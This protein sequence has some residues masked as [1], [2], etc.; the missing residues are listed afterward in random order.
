MKKLLALLLAGMMVFSL[1]ACGGG[2]K[3]EENNAPAVEEPAGVKVELKDA[4]G[5]VS[6]DVYYPEAAELD[7]L[8]YSDSKSLLQDDGDYKID[9][10]LVADDRYEKLKG[11][12]KMGSDVTEGKFG[13]YDCITCLKDGNYVTF[14][15]LEK[16]DDKDVYLEI[17]VS[18]GSSENTTP[19]KEIYDTNAEVKE[20]IESFVYNGKI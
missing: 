20:I 17:L 8:E 9:F 14:V 3:P 19:S 4:S 5:M 6:A 13:A 7:V 15:Y 1:A 16:L 18:S 11:Y 2:E 10:R 12:Y